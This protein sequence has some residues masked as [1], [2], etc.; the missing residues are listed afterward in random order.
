MIRRPS[1]YLPLPD[2]PDWFVNPPEAVER[3][4]GTVA[5]NVVVKFAIREEFDAIPGRFRCSP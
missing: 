1:V 5:I 3:S 4:D 2:S